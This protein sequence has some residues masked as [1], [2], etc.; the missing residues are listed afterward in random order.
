MQAGGQ[1]CA[2]A[3]THAARERDPG[4][5]QGRNR[6]CVAAH[7][8]PGGDTAQAWPLRYRMSGSTVARRPRRSRDVRGLLWNVEVCTTTR[9]SREPRRV[10]HLARG[11]QG[12]HTEDHAGPAFV[13]GTLVLEPRATLRSLTAPMSPCCEDTQATGTA[14]LGAGVLPKRPGRVQPLP[15]TS[16]GPRHGT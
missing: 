15:H 1:G 13:T 9:S 4:H 10:H 14:R 11:L 7:S 5:S 8:A 3:H 2:H 6:V 16:P 12:Q